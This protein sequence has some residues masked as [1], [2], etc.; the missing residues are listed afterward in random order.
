MSKLE[1]PLAVLGWRRGLAAAGLLAAL[2]AAVPASAFVGELR[3]PKVDGELALPGLTAKVRVLRDEHGIP[4][5]FAANTP[6]LI[7]AQGFVTAQD[8]IFQMEGLRAVATGRLAESVGEGGLA[9]DRQIRLL[10]LRRNAER[11]AKL[12]SPEAREFLLWYAEGMNA[13]ITGHADDHPLELKLAGFVPRPWTLEDMVTVLHIGNWSQAANFK[14]ELNMQKLIDK[15]GADKVMRELLPVNVNPDR[16]LRP[17][18]VGRAAPAQPLGEVTLLAGLDE[19]AAPIAPLALGS[20]NWAIGKSRSASGAAVLVNDPHLDAR[21][22][23]GIWHP[24]GLFTPDIQAIGAAYPATP[25][26]VVGRTA[27]VAFGV[28]NAYGDSQDLFIEKVAPGRP[29][30]YVDGEQVR[31]FQ[32]IEEVIRIKDKDAPGGFREET[33]R[34]RATVRGPVISGPVF[35]YDGESLLSLRMASAELAGGPIGV[36][37]LLTARNIADVDKAAQAMDIVYFNYV[38]ADKAGGI[39]HRATGRVPVRASGQGAYPKPVGSSDDWR[40]FIP[41]DQ[42]PGMI[43]PARDWVGTANHDTRPDGYAFDYSSYFASSY[44]YRRIIEVLDAGKAM[45]TEDQSALMMDAHNLQAPRVLPAL[46]AALQGDPANGDLAGILAAWD[47]RDDKD[48]AAPLIYHTLYERLVWETYVDE[49]GD[50][51][52]RSWLGQWYTWQ[53][54]FDEL[55]KTPDSPWFDDIRTPQKETL[56]DLVRRVAAQARPELQARHGADPAQWKWGDEHR[57]YFYS[58]L[59]RSGTGRDWLGYA[60]APMSG[61]SST[62]LRALTPFMGGFNVEFFA[63]MRLVADLGD[64]EK[65]QAVVAGG[66]VDRQFHPHQKDQLP[67]WSEGRLLNWW[68]APAQVEAHARQ[69]QELLPR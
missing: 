42:M 1:Q 62:L 13:Y 64:D 46:V 41:P 50:K 56:P 30:H 68:F 12:L 49:M 63:S 19:P 2:A 15:F 59:R 36:D 35:G 22:L 16:R 4:Y 39:G 7:R 17:V 40:G 65:I 57:I 43:A 47:G 3:G 32:I 33:M 5:I 8:R 58:P 69:R 54:R 9:S 52:A 23:P 26:L 20:N 14:A 24:I 11:H 61:S 53:E 34:I 25:G 60:E 18:I 55:V 45:R 28:T 44:R 31:P 48:L 67:A 10:G 51:L 29:D 37:Q 38:F 27:F 6:D 21:M 66:V